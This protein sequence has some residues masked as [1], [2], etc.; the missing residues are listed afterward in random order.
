[1]VVDSCGG[2]E[3]L[4]FFKDVAIRSL[5]GFHA[6]VGNSR[7]MHNEQPELT[8][9]VERKV[10]KGG[11]GGAKNMKMGGAFLMEGPGELKGGRKECT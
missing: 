10:V 8:Q 1:M 2:R 4:F 6:P 7:T 3:S 9:P 11:G 5:V